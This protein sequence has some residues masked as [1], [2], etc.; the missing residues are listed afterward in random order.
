MTCPKSRSF[1]AATTPRRNCSGCSLCAKG[2]KFETVVLLAGYLGVCV[3]AKRAACNGKTLILRRNVLCIRGSLED[4]RQVQ[5]LVL[6]RNQN[7]VQLSYSADSA[8]PCGLLAAAQE[9]NSSSSGCWAGQVMIR[10]WEGFVCVDA[11]G[12]IT[13]PKYVSRY[14]SDLLREKWASQ[15]PFPRPETFLRNFAAGKWRDFEAGAGVA[16]ASQL[17]GHSGHIRSCF[18]RIQ[19]RNGRYDVKTFG[20]RAGRLTA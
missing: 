20:Q 1:A 11:M 4:A 14:F 16:G 9:R 18:G 13:N 8:K 3:R 5:G 6:W 10:E 15:N 7:G 17:C 12:D 19:A 2:T